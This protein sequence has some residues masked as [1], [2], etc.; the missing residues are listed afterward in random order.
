MAQ[1]D[2][3]FYETFYAVHNNHQE[4]NFGTFAGHHK[5]LVKNY[6]NE[7]CLTTDYS[8]ATLVSEF[9]YSHHIKKTYF[10]EGTI[11]GQITLA[12][13]SDDST[14]T[15]YKISLWKI[16]E[17]NEKNELFTTGWVTVDDALIWDATYDIG[18]DRV[19]AFEIDAWE[20]EELSDKERFFLKVEVNCNAYTVLWHSNSATW[21]DI[22]IEIPFKL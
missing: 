14:V 17:N 1:D 20:K 8:S 4:I 9:I 2:M 15:S 19:Y 12:A 3:R 6:I 21:E 13:Q 10:I 18:E 16:H 11:K 7:A 22:K 5:L